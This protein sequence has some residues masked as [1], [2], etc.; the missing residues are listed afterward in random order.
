MLLQFILHIIGYDIWFYVSHLM[1]HTRLLWWMH[2]IHHEK[3]RPTFMETYHGHWF[4]GPFQSVGFLLPFALGFLDFR[5]A[6]W[7]TVAVNARGLLRHDARSVWLIGNHHLLHHEIGN[8]NYG[9][10]WVDRLFGTAATPERQVR[11]I[12]Y[13]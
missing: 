4:E 2:K 12:F 11:G 13:V 5:A 9:D 8:V 1:L 7:A 10:Y 6:F 3:V